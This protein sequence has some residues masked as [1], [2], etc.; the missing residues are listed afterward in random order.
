MVFDESGAQVASALREYRHRPVPGAPGS[1][2][3]DTAHAWSLLADCVRQA[4]V[5]ASTAGHVGPVAAV[6][7]TSMRE[8]MVL[9]DVAGREIWACPNV[10][11]RAGE[12][13]AAL[14]RSGAARRIFEQAGDWVSITAPARFAWLVEREPRV[15]AA[16]AHIGMLGDWVT[17]RLTGEFVTDPSLGS[18]SGMFDLARRNWSPEILELCGLE[19]AIFPPVLEPGAVVGTIRPRV[20]EELGLPT[21]IPVVVGGADTQLALLGLGAGQPG[22]FTLVGGSFWQATLVTATPLIDPAARLRTLCH[23]VRDRWMVEGIGFYCGL[24]MRWFRDGFCEAEK[25]AASRLGA[26]AYD[27][28]E[29]QAA[30][31]PAGSN[32]TFA[33]FSNLMQASRWVQAPPTFVGFDVT[34]PVGSGRMACFR[35]IEEAAAYVAHG[36]RLMLEELGEHAID[37]VVFTGGAGKGTLWSRIVC[38]VLGLPTKVPVVKESTALGAALLAGVGAGLWGDACEKG[39]AACRYE[40]VLE[41]D[42]KAHV[43]Y[44]ELFER[45][46]AIYA[47]ELALAESRLVRPLWWPAGADET[48]PASLHGVD[49]ESPL[50]PA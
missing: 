24:V 15:L 27:L 23:A 11:S 20:A 2:S 50:S 44:L 19:R 33:V 5:A 37:E 42:P 25:D 39:A 6:A 31:L 16:T 14:V 3:F 40:V 36:H 41:P 4:V 9:Y 30:A 7:A 26:D 35:A 22:R 43:A 32:G 8:G 1:Q 21:G 47:H 13:A 28:L 17:T 18:S 49:S 45:W 29:A 10:D 38:D 48:E 34:D 46:R 12:Q